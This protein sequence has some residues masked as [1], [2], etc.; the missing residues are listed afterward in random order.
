M[1]TRTTDRFALPPTAPGNQREIILHRFGRKGSGQKAYIQASLHADETPAMMAAHHLLQLLER[2]DQEGRI[3]GEIVLVPYA[4]PI[5]TAQWVNGYQLGR[6]E[7]SGGGNFNRNW[8]KLFAQ[9]GDL[10]EGKLGADAKANV[11]LIRAALREI[12]AQSSAR[13]EMDNLRLILLR[14]SIDSDLCLDIHCDDDSLLHLFLIPQHWPEASDIAAEL[15]V[16]AVMLAEDSGGNSFDEVNSNGWV[17]LQKRF[18]NHPIPA[19]CVAATVELRGQP[20]VSDELG[21]KDAAALYR[22]LVRRG[23]IAGD[24]PPLP[25]LLCEATDLSATDTIK[26]P[27]QGIMAYKVELGQQ[28]TKGTVI[29]ELIDP[30]APP[31][32]P[33]IKIVTET[34]GL[35]LSKRQHKYIGPGHSVAKVIGK[36]PLP[37]RKGV[38]LED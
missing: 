25:P 4:N 18:K 19:A 6:Y 12:L 23:Y 5:G 14:E 32:A 9:A 37:S 3:K 22:V 33:R 10:V 24:V 21:A 26:S 38:L 16:R 17:E 7:L 35:V 29:A 15:G 28:V 20:D 8:P 1:P 11:A 36:T 13:K 2:A 30:A 34:D 27:A 31:G